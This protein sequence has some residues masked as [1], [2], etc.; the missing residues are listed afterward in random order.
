M[1]EVKKDVPPLVTIETSSFCNRHC[2]WCPQHDHH[3]IQEKL[4][5]DLFDKVIKELAEVGFEGK[6][7]L[8]FF[9]EPLLDDRLEDMI[10]KIKKTIKSSI[11]YI[12]TNGDAM[13][14]ARL[15]SLLNA[16]LDGCQINQYEQEVSEGIKTLLDETTDDEKAKFSVRMF[17]HRH[18]FNRAGLVKTRRQVPIQK[19]CRRIR[20][21]C[22][23]Y[24]GDVVLCCNDFF[25]QVCV[26]NVRD[27]N[28][29]DLYNS[30]VLK[31]YRY[32][33]RRGRRALLKLC[34]KCDL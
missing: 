28:V 21:M 3:R 15:R 20:Q 11:V 6:I 16:G 1:S 33:L 14:S 9:N 24:K 18:I 25:G 13:T 22:V 27:S 17:G 19:Q 26:G 34:D 8:H 29:I 7:G 23:N 4:P 5:D 12:H 30:P 10:V 31:D 32:K 2:E